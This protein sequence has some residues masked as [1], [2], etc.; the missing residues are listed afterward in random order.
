MYRTLAFFAA[1][2]CVLALFDW[3]YGYY[4]LLRFGVCAVAIYGA[5]L[6]HQAGVQGW[7]WALGALAVVFNPL[8]PVYLDRSVWAVIDIAAAVVLVLSSLTVS[9]P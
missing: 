9:R 7:T 2:A 4:Q 3:P 6:A 5:V 8:L 1:A